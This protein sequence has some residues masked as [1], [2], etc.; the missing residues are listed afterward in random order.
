MRK[1]IHSKCAYGFLTK[2]GTWTKDVQEAAVF[3]DHS[4]A[5]AAVEQF[6][7]RE[8]ELYFNFSDD[9]TTEYDFAVPLH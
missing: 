8:V 3:A 2:D 5:R 6:Q 4:E 9:G 1:L 7:L